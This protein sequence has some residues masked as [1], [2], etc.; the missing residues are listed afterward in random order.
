MESKKENQKLLEQLSSENTKI[1]ALEAEVSHLQETNNMLNDK[2]NK[3]QFALDSVEDKAD[4]DQATIDSLTETEVKQQIEIDSLIKK[5][6]EQQDTI[7][8]MTIAAFELEQLVSSTK[9]DLEKYQRIATTQEE[10]STLLESELQDLQASHDKATSILAAT[11]SD[12]ETT[13]SQLQIQLQAIETLT[14]QVL[15]LFACS[16]K[17]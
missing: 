1:N 15:L 17:Y 12:Y 13:Q 16:F 3:Q 9:I 5:L 10:K 4:E 6:S 14:L 7:K 2:L 11:K 8:E